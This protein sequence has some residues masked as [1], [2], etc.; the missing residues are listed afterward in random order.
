MSSQTIHDKCCCGI[1]KRTSGSIPGDAVLDRV[2]QFIG[3]ARLLRI[4]NGRP[5]HL[6]SIGRWT[7]GSV[8][9]RSA[10]EGGFP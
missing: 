7:V 8:V 3:G 6:R 9:A 5:R 4:I 1:T 2:T 10:R